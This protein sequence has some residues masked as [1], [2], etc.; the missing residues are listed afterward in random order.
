V[1]VTIFLHFGETRDLAFVDRFLEMI[2]TDVAVA[3]KDAFNAKSKECNYSEGHMNFN[4]VEHFSPG[5]WFV[6]SVGGEADYI[7]Q[8][9]T[10]AQKNMEAGDGGDGNPTFVLLS[11][12]WFLI[13]KYIIFELYPLLAPKCRVGEGEKILRDSERMHAAP[14]T[15]QP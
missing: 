14:L 6:A 5:C 8:T 1:P 12:V 4:V 10:S 9:W 7:D 15:P 3:I 13:V 11:R 2:R